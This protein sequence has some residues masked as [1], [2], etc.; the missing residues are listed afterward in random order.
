MARRKATRGNCVF[1]G[2]NYTRGG[3]S[4]HLAS[5]KARQTQQTTLPGRG[6]WSGEIYHLIVK[7]KYGGDFWLH[8]DM[9]GKSTLADLDDYLR[10]IWLEC[11]GHLS[12][13]N[14]A[15]FRYTKNFPDGWGF[16]KEK[17]LDTA[18]GTIFTP[19]ITIP[20]DYDFGSTTSLE[21]K[22]IRQRQGKWGGNPIQLMAR[23]LPLELT[24]ATCGKPADEVCMECQWEPDIS[25]FYC[26]ECFTSHPCEEEMSLPVVNSPRMGQCGYEGPAEPPY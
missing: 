21:I 22:V 13:F 20:Y 15:P 2:K 5:C 24:C 12:A 19:G 25:P 26:N 9:P 4:K 6:Q 18:I 1:C 17:S 23:N 16:D 7:D 10:A 11:C 14:I 3:L 8:L